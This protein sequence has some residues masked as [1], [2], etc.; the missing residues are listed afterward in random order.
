MLARYPLKLCLLLALGK[1]RRAY[2]VLRGADECVL[3]ITIYMSSRTE[4]FT[5]DHRTLKTSSPVRSAIFHDVGCP[6][7][8]PD[9][10]N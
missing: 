1:V 3:L 10:T 2:V 4:T 8:E 7:Q 5:Y 6:K 9:F